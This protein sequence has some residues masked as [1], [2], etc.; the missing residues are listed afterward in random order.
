MSFQK[1]NLKCVGGGGVSIRQELVGENRVSEFPPNVKVLLDSGK[2]AIDTVIEI[3][4]GDY[5]RLFGQGD[6]LGVDF[7]ELK[8]RTSQSGIGY[9]ELFRDR[10]VRLDAL[11]GAQRS[12]MFWYS[13]LQFCHEL[14]KG[15]S[16]RGDF[17]PLPESSFDRIDIGTDDE[18]ARS[19]RLN[20]VDFQNYLP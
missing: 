2:P 16:D 15:A 20:L 7:E 9:L 11:K 17:P 5:I 10:M 6:I 19:H 13:R 1:H 14:I 18:A 12:H 3:L 8:C 4:W